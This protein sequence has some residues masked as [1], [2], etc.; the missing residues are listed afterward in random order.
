MKRTGLISILLLALLAVNIVGWLRIRSQGRLTRFSQI[1]RPDCVSSCVTAPDASCILLPID[2][3]TM[4]QFRTLA[5]WF[6]QA[7]TRS[8]REISALFGVTDAT[9]IALR[10]DTSLAGGTLLNVGAPANIA[11]PN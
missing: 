3:Q 10:S 11:S 2:G 4:T 1:Q 8:S 9:S 5:G 6:S 7:G